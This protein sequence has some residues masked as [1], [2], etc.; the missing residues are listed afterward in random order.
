MASALELAFPTPPAPPPPELTFEE[1]DTLLRDAHVLASALAELSEDARAGDGQVLV[2]LVRPKLAAA[3]GPLE[4]W[5]ATAAGAAQVDRRSLR[6]LYDDTQA[7]VAAGDD[8]ETCARP[9]LPHTYADDT[10]GRT[11]GSAI[12]PRRRSL[13]ARVA[14]ALGHEQDKDDGAVP[15]LRSQELGLSFTSAVGVFAVATMV[16]VSLAGRRRPF[17]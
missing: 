9:P 3:R 6:R 10:A 13:Y 1:V 2:G 15:G 8:V 12:R 14:S 7:I 4:R 11:G 17:S 5:M 16:Y